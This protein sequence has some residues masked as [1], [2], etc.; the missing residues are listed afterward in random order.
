MYIIKKIAKKK[1]R[2]HSKDEF[3]DKAYIPKGTVYIQVCNG[4]IGQG[5]RYKNYTIDCIK[6]VLSGS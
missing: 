2:L 1:T 3:I 5:R 6:A 4:T